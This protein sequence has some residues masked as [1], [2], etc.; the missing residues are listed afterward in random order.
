[1]PKQPL[2]DKADVTWYLSILAVSTAQLY[3]ASLEIYNGRKSQSCLLRVFN[4][5]LGSF[6][7]K[8]C[9]FT[10]CIQPLLELKTRPGFCPVTWSLSMLNI[11]ILTADHSERWSFSIMTCSRTL[12]KQWKRN[13]KYT[14]TLTLLSDECHSAECRHP[15][16]AQPPGFACK[17]YTCIRK[18]F[19][20]RINQ[21]YYWGLFCTT[22]EHYNY[23]QLIKFIKVETIYI[24]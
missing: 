18:E 22:H 16:A 1:M 7:S 17:Y 8:Q 5:K 13:C 21:I 24:R 10:S 14:I 12:C 4:F 20:S 15:V 23:L 11:V 6:T 19:L 3:S 9:K 2:F